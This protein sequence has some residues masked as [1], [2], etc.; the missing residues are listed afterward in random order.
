VGEELAVVS[1]ANEVFT[2]DLTVDADG[3]VIDYPGLA[4]GP[5]WASAGGDPGG[6]PPPTDCAIPVCAGADRFTA[7]VLGYRLGSRHPCFDLVRHPGLDGSPGAYPAFQTAP[8]A[9]AC[10]LCTDRGTQR[11]A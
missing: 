9:L 7:R 4:T 8:E 3:L 2:T 10:E 1:V 11:V 6:S 5:D